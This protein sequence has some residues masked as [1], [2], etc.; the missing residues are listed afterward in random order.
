MVF[1]YIISEMRP[2]VTCEKPSFR[3]LILGLTQSKDETILPNR[4]Q[5]SKQLTENYNAYVLMLTDLIEKQNYICTTADIWSGN[6][7]SYMGMYDICVHFVICSQ[8]F[9]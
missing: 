4:K 1:E 6:N 2:L 5:I 3:N 8:T 9:I 7:K